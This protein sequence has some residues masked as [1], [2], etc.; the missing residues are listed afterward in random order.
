MDYQLQGILIYV[1]ATLYQHLFVKDTLY[2]T[3]YDIVMLCGI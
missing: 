2:D 1:I 3:K